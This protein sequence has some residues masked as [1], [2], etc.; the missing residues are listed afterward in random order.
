M[1]F[2]FA[3]ILHTRWSKT[4][5]FPALGTDIPCNEDVYGTPSLVKAESLVGRCCIA[6]LAS[7]LRIEGSRF[8]VVFTENQGYKGAM[9]TKKCPEITAFNIRRL[10]HLKSAL[11]YKS[12]GCPSTICYS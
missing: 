4:R 8:R 11:L 10:S 5:R 7:S 3:V 6:I 9:I 2:W 12:V 1:I